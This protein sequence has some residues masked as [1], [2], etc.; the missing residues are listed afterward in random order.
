MD[1]IF[2]A[3]LAAAVVHVLEEYVY[4]GGFS[5]TLKRFL[6][7]SAHLVTPRFSVIINGLFI[8]LC[9][10]G[11]AVGRDNLMFSL[12]VASLLFINSCAHIGR[13]V[14]ARAYTPGLVSSLLLYIPLSSYAYYLFLSSGDITLP[15]SIIS[16][17]LGAL[18]QAVPVGY[19]LLPGATR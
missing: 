18:Y 6:P 14:L 7:K 19:L 13:T 5:E 16:G 12:S 4:P 17:L 11:A 10:L 3:L 2:D 9:I 8:L 1:W 15:G